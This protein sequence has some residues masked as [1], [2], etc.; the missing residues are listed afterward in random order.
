MILRSITKSKFILLLPVLS[1][2]LLTF[3]VAVGE[4]NPRLTFHVSDPRDTFQFSSDAPLEKIV[5]TTNNIAGKVIVHPDDITENLQASFE[6]DLATIETGI[7]ERDKHLRNEYLETQKYP[8]AMLTVDDIIKVN[9]ENTNASWRLEDKKIFYV[10]AQCTLK[11]HGVQ[12]SIIVDKVKIT[13]FKENDELRAVNMY[14][15]I[16]KID[17]TFKV[18]L[19]DYNIKRPQLLFLKLSEELEIKISMSVSYTHL[20]LPTKA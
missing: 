3:C 14:G 18:N 2:F 16:L 7:A 13:Y 11:L 10:T 1:F 5:G 20:T 4:D 17:A 8:K 15:N 12:K 9:G 19:S 6:L